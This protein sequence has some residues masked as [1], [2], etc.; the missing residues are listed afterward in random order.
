MP[1]H[2]L[3]LKPRASSSLLLKVQIRPMW[4]Y[5][6]LKITGKH[7]MS[8]GWIMIA[9]FTLSCAYTPNALISARLSVLSVIIQSQAEVVF[10]S[11]EEIW[12]KRARET[13]LHSD[14][15]E[16]FSRF[17]RKKGSRSWGRM[18]RWT[19]PKAYPSWHA[20]GLGCNDNRR[21]RCRWEPAK[22]SITMGKVETRQRNKTWWS[23]F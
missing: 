19:P 15:P 22:S 2:L 18:L 13:F 4:L 10:L 12:D 17:S 3:A 5:K 14:E 21:H 1:G 23:Q 20:T 9:L 7:L 6:E 16:T 8:G 11:W